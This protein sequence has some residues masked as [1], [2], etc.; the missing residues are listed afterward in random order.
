MELLYPI[1]P[2]L[3]S[4][5]GLAVAVEWV[6]WQRQR[7]ESRRRSPLS[8][9][10]LRSSGSSKRAEFDELAVD[11]DAWLFLAALGPL[12][13]FSVH[14]AQSYLVGT[15]ESLVRIG[16]S[17]VAG[18]VML[19]VAISKLH[20]LAK[21]RWQLRCGMEAELA[22]GRELDQLMRSGAV[23]FHDVPAEHF[24]IDHVVITQGGLY[25]VETKGRTKPKTDR[26]KEG[27]TVVY[28]GKV[29][30]FPDWVEREP[31]EQA[32]R[33]AKWLAKW[34]TSAVGEKV[35]VKPVV[36][37]PGWYVERKARN[38]VNVISG[39][40]API[41]LKGTPGLTLADSLVRRIAHQLEQRCRDVEPV[42]YRKGRRV[43]FQR[44]GK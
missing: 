31:I 43:E 32:R 21:R 42:F 16:L 2:I 17:V 8:A 24:N 13:V 27:V 36:A 23:V 5:L 41:L 40:E 38:D 30:T 12:I 34:L 7:Y 10:L 14:V 9:K 22:M 15:P 33:Q 26:G 35:E 4:I 18:L 44:R 6:S 11:R 39:M 20:T 19:V 37:L 25:A 3:L 28:D 29:L 1:I